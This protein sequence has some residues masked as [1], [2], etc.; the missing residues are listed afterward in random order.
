MRILRPALFLLFSF[1]LTACQFTGD[2]DWPDLENDGYIRTIT[3]EL[4]ARSGGSSNRLNERIMQFAAD[5]SDIRIQIRSNNNHPSDYS[6]WILG[7]KGKDD[8]PDIVE[9]TPA[10]MKLWFHHGKIEALTLAEP[11]YRDHVIMSHDGFVL[12]LK[13]KINPLIVYYNQE[14]FAR[15]GLESP[16]NDWDWNK[17][18]D[19]I[20]KLKTAGEKVYVMISPAILEMVTMSRYGGK[21]VDSSGT[22]FSGYLDSEAAVQAAEWLSW[23]GTRVDQY[24]ERKIGS[25]NTYM[26]MPYDLIE[27]NMALAVDFAFALQTTGIT[28]YADI[29][30]RNP[31]IHIA[32]LPGGFDTINVARMSGLSIHAE[33]KNKDIA[34]ELIRYLAQEGDLFFLDA[35]QHTHDS[36][37]GKEPVS[38]DA[39]SILL[40]EARRSVP[41]TLYMHEGQNH[42]DND[43]YFRPRRLILSGQTAKDALAQEAADIE[44]QFEMFK[45]DMESYASCI[46]NYSGVCGS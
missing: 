15:L 10:Q 20:A 32:N 35:I 27:D 23:I 42:G 14:I 3:I 36:Y 26:P 19:T 31:R 16:A 29:I 39:R 24:K 41:A 34:M 11:Q 18:D 1:V 17:L 40:Y 44:A 13:T 43:A 12:G 33:S 25:S 6:P 2:G 5:R 37:G 30:Q 7:R 45:K 46:R 22:V 28:S 8:P 38:A 21:I 9:L 4:V